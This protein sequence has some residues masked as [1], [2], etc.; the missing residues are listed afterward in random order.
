MRTIFTK[1]KLKNPEKAR[2][3]KIYRKAIKDGILTRM[4]CRVCGKPNAEGHHED[5]SKPLEVIPL[6]RRHHAALSRKPRIAT[7]QIQGLNEKSEES[8]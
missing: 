7:T 6:C 8:K 3:H 4:P 1:Y 2:A 5:Y